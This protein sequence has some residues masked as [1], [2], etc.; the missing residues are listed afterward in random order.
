MTTLRVLTIV[1]VSL[2][3]T[4][5]KP[6][7]VEGTCTSGTSKEDYYKLKSEEI[8]RDAYTSAVI[9]HLGC[10]RTLTADQLKMCGDPPKW[11]EF[12]AK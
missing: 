12:S 7:L 1:A 8:R 5:C 11:A 4:S 2:L 3:S 9:N 10:I 6:L